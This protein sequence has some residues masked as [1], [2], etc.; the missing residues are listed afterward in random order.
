VSLSKTTNL[1]FC[2]G[3]GMNILFGDF[4]TLFELSM[5]NIIDSVQL[6]SR[7]LQSSLLRI[8]DYRRCEGLNR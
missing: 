3:I 4:L 8:L 6:F 5:A 2:D 1:I 7:S